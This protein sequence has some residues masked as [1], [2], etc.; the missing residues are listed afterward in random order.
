[1][2]AFRLVPPRIAVIPSNLFTRNIRSQQ[3]IKLHDYS[4]HIENLIRNQK[5]KLADRAAIVLQT[6]Q[7]WVSFTS[8][9][10]WSLLVL[11]LST[12]AAEAVPKD[13]LEGDGWD[14]HILSPIWNLF[15]TVMTLNSAKISLVV[16]AW[17]NCTRLMQNST[18]YFHF[19]VPTEKI[20]MFC[21]EY[22]YW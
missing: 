21:A 6:T 8:R 9:A 1:M 4:M 16:I 17:T 5:W 12:P 11:L 10:S 3:A 7:M 19:V 2:F 22:I 18:N 20:T 14:E 13:A 15:C